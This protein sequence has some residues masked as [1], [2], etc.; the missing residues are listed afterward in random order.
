MWSGFWDACEVF[1][2]KKRQAMGS[3]FDFIVVVWAFYA[4]SRCVKGAK[5]VLS[6]FGRPTPKRPNRGETDWSLNKNECH[7]DHYV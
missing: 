7:K 3:L 2:V 4:C 6:E 5:A 1:F